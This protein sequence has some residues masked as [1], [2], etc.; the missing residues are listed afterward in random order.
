M[1]IGIGKI[2]FQYTIKRS[3]LQVE[4]EVLAMKMNGLKMFMR[5]YMMM[6]MMVTTILLAGIT[7]QILPAIVILQL[8][9]TSTLQMLTMGH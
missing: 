7:I 1:T 3:M 6:T 8:T 4:E 5:K 2:I 9:C